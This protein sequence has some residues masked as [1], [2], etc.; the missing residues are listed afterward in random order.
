MSKV[1]FWVVVI[2]VGLLVMRLAA[3]H[4]A[5]RNNPRRNPKS[6]R[7]QC[8]RNRVETMVQCAHSGVHLPSDEAIH[9][10]GKHWCSVEHA[11]LG[12]H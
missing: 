1:L 6:T 9:S 2:F 11:R 7:R 3:R 4:A 10:L 8:Q 12:P 5:H